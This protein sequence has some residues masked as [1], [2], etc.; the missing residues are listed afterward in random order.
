MAD[1]P[2]IDFEPLQEQGKTIR[3]N[4]VQIDFQAEPTPPPSMSQKILDTA[5]SAV[6]RLP[7]V[8]LNI[9]QPGLPIS[10]YAAK[11]PALVA[12]GLTLGMGRQ[13]NAGLQS[14]M[15]VVDQ[16]VNGNNAFGN[17]SVPQATFRQRVVDAISNA[18]ENYSKVKK[19][20]QAK[21]D[22]AR[23]SDPIK[24]AL[25]EMVAS[26][27]A[28]IIAGPAF[29]AVGIA[30]PVIQAAT[31]GGAYGY[32]ASNKEG[33]SRATDAAESATLAGGVAGA[34]K[35]GGAIKDASGKI[36]QAAKAIASEFSDY[37]KPIINIREAQIKPTEYGLD[38]KAK[39]GDTFQI[40]KELASTLTNENIQ[41]QITQEFNAQPQIVDDI[42][43]ST[44]QKLGAIRDSLLIEHG[45]A[46][47]KPQASDGLLTKIYNKA[48]S[49]D[50]AGDASA[51][52]LKQNL[53]SKITDFSQGAI[54]PVTGRSSLT[55][56]AITD[57][58]K[59]LGKS[60][61]EDGAYSNH[62]GIQ[63]AAKNIWG[64][65]ADAANALDETQGSG[66]MI[67]DI[68][69]TFKA[70]YGMEENSIKGT[71]IKAM[72]NPQSAAADNKFAEFVKP[73]QDLPPNLRET[74]APEMHDY[75]ANQFPKV[76]A[77]AKAM[78]AVGGGAENLGV[79]KTIFS[80]SGLRGLLDASFH[81]PA[82]LAGKLSNIQSPAL[83]A[84]TSLAGQAGP[85][86]LPVIAPSLGAQLG[87]K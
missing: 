79:S 62:R 60:V 3:D 10:D 61:F 7:E 19:E 45:D 65:V 42:L 78:I 55:L 25:T 28:S 50:T 77:K 43:Q 53:L 23:T 46:A 13:A 20:E 35:I 39:L 22:A 38:M 34:F 40:S 56:K 84:A 48:G 12:Q 83:S 80:L 59:T 18:P 31:L 87:S 63:G 58:Q 86:V 9:A 52:S 69:K 37:M 68:N 57:F 85:T 71:T 70:L 49:I 29:K 82:S 73:F 36:P 15:G 30:S 8:A 67:S 72:V 64:Q 32:G 4:A 16:A 6:A 14:A 5:K 2:Q 17:E 51:E 75:L 81:Y 27:P 33:L 47:L 76:F 26:V 54:D 41:K 21:I 24:A 44:K 11:N 1:Q 66:G 74:L